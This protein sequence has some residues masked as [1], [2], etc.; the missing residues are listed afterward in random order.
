M[1]RGHC[2][3]DEEFLDAIETELRHRFAPPFDG[4]AFFNDTLF[5]F[6]LDKAGEDLGYLDAEA[7]KIL[8]VVRRH[9]HKPDYDAKMRVDNSIPAIKFKWYTP[10]ACRKVTITRGNI[11]VRDMACDE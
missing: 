9:Y 4:T 5:D 8:A 1:S 11:A 2:V 10:S 6:I 7:H 3:T